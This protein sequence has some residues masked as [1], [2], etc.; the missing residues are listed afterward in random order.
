MQTL[1]IPFFPWFYDSILT[2]SLDSYQEYLCEEFGVADCDELES[3]I[4][5]DW[6]KT[7]DTTARAFLTSLK[8]KLP[9]LS[10]K[11]GVTLGDYYRLVSPQFYNYGTDEVE[12]FYEIDETKAKEYLQE[13][14][15]KFAEYIK[16]RNTSYDGFTAY[17]QNDFDEFINTEFE[18]W[19][20]T[21]I[22][23]FYIM[24]EDESGAHYMNMPIIDELIMELCPYIEYTE[25]TI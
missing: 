3:K 21:E 10:E 16:E 17:F 11:T 25:K 2:C 12:A 13:N 6:N 5:I 4:D 20:V 8:E 22:I 24:Q 9:E 23:E 19:K 14:K 18:P 7:Y 1:Y 15:A